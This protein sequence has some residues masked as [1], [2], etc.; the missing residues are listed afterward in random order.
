MRY[1]AIAALLVFG[2]GCGTDSTSTATT[3]TV[4]VT[5]GGICAE[6]D[7]ELRMVAFGIDTSEHRTV[8]EMHQD[9]TGEID[10]ELVAAVARQCPTIAAEWASL[11]D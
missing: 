8:L 9:A 10:D 5:V 11:S 7:A 1:T 2:T 3:T 4:A 6:M